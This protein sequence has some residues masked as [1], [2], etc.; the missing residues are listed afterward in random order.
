MVKAKKERNFN[1]FITKIA[2]KHKLSLQGSVKTELDQMIKFLISEVATNSSVIM[3]DYLKAQKTVKPT[4]I[5]SAIEILL[6]GSLRHNALEA[7][8]KAVKNSEVLKA[9]KKAE[10]LAKSAAA[11]EE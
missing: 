1:S 10:R 3:R 5:K 4:T 2:K 9:N 6:H 8:E 11:V 7:A